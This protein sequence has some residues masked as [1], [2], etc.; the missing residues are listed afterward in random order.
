[1]TM[2]E[3]QENSHRDQIDRYVNE[4]MTDDERVVFEQRMREHAELAQAVHTHKDVLQGIELYFLKQ[5]K[6]TLILSDQPKK[7]GLPLWVKIAIGVGV[8]G[9]L[10][11]LA[12]YLKIF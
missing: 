4:K 9:I 1:M 10:L 2:S 7:S 6:E 5:L 3:S 11:A 12:F 8:A